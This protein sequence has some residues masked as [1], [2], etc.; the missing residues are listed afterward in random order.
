LYLN[1]STWMEYFVFEYF[2][3]TEN[4]HFVMTIAE[5]IVI[6]EYFDLME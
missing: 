3:L 6:F 1:I 2:H 4:F 5:G